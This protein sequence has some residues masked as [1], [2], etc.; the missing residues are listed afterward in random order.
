[1]ATI[2]GNKLA[3]LAA[4]GPCPNCLLFIC[5]D[6]FLADSYFQKFADI[7]L[8]Q[9]RE[10][11]YSIFE[12]KTT[13]ADVLANAL[14]SMAFVPGL[15]LVK[16]VGDSLPKDGDMSKFLSGYLQ[17]PNPESIL[18]IMV[19]NVDKRTSLYRLFSKH[20]L[21]VEVDRLAKAEV[22]RQ[23]ASSFKKDGFAIDSDALGFLIENIGYN[24]RDAKVDFGIFK[25]EVAKLKWHNPSQK[26][27]T[28]AA[29]R[30]TITSSSYNNLLEYSS[31]VAAADVSN[32]IASLCSC[33]EDNQ[34][35][36]KLL[37]ELART[38][39]NIAICQSAY[40]QGKSAQDI[41]RDY[42][43]HPFVVQKS[44]EAKNRYSVADAANALKAVL[45]VDA[46]IKSGQIDDK[47]AL[48]ALTVDLAA[49][50]FVFAS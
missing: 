32:A 43:L 41:A 36:L 33:F 20:G 15:R 13:S 18:A 9:D 17:N 11:S 14:L 27:I 30:N 44:I 28:L 25:G 50:V 47:T 38:M 10:L 31:Y 6:R 16:M 24:N 7:I 37:S 39:R 21:V 19:D 49:K 34:P 45:N 26:R 42:S 2:K 48:E 46:A 22:R 8:T 23:I 3:A 5:D 12:I 35:P 4:K 40:Y 1:M 29:A